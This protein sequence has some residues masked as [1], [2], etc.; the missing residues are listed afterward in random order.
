MLQENVMNAFSIIITLKT[1]ITLLTMS[2]ALSGCAGGDVNKSAEQTDRDV[3][4]ADESADSPAAD[5]C[6]LEYDNTCGELALALCECPDDLNP[7]SDF[8]HYEDILEMA[9]KAQKHPELNA[10]CEVFLE[11]F[12]FGGGCNIE[13]ETGRCT[14]KHLSHV[15]SLAEVEHCVTID[16]DLTISNTSVM[17]L[18][19]LE[20]LTSITGSLRIEDNDQLVDLSG[21]ENITSL[22]GQL[23]I[24]NNPHLR[25]LS[26]I[27]NLSEVG[28]G[29]AI[30][31]NTQLEHVSLDNVSNVGKS[32][33]IWDNHSLYSI[34]MSD[35]KTIGSR[36]DSEH[37]QESGTL[38]TLWLS[39]NEDLES[40][41]FK[42]LNFVRGQLNIGQ[43]Q[44]E[45]LDG[46]ESLITGTLRGDVNIY[47]NPL[48]CR[49]YIDD[50]ITILG[51]VG[52]SGEA[53]IY[54]N[55]DC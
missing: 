34:S 29:V 32:V 4:I 21:L 18:S 37:E 49:S 30:S 39:G 2:V 45:T 6:A 23:T 24:E 54:D 14:D 44:L 9:S 1:L 13:E 47:E 35:L 48:M 38:G 27:E 7:I 42:R 3:E 12:E 31:G 52:W 26:G 53:S 5:A 25:D 36:V 11:L 33:L 28:D 50:L 43:T 22:D 46:F 19:E 10:D 40:I 15:D 8:A 17:D 55:G 41:S 20:N 51:L 16:G